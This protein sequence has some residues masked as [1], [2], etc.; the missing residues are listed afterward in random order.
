MTSTPVL[1]TAVVCLLNGY[2]NLEIGNSVIIIA[3]FIVFFIMTE[4]K[5]F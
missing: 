5:L 1:L 2:S 4:S 3:G